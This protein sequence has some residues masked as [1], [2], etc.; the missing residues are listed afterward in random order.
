MPASTCWQCRATVRADRPGERLGHGGRHGGGF[1]PGGVEQR[2]GRLQGH[3][4]LGQPVADGLEG[5]DGSPELHAFQCVGC[6]R[7]RASPAPRRRARGRGRAAPAPPRPASRPARL[8]AARPLEF[9]RHFE[10]AERGVE[11]RAPAGVSAGQVDGEGRERRRPSAATTSAVLGAVECR[12]AQPSTTHQSPSSRP[13]G[14]HRRAAAGR[15][16]TAGVAVTPSAAPAASRAPPTWRSSPPGSRRARRRRWGGRHRA[17]PANRDRR[18]RASSAAPLGGSVACRTPRFEQRTLGRLHQRS[19][20]EVEQPAGDDVALDL[21]AAPV[22][23]GRP[24]IE[25]LGPPALADRVVAERRPPRPALRRRGRTPPARPS[26]PGPCRWRSRPERSPAASRRCVARE[27]A[28]KAHK[29]SVASPTATGSSASG[30]ARGEQLLQAPLQVGGPVPQRRAALVGQ[31]VHGDGPAVIHLAEDPVERH[32]TS[33][34]KT[35]QNSWAP[36]IVSIGR[37]VMPALS[38]SMKS[39]VMPLC[40]DS[41]VPVRVSSTHRARTGPGSS[42]PSGR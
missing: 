7:A 27:R 29:S 34:K 35:S 23:G 18:G 21:G 40:A 1:L 33:S 6:G 9:A 37:T 3:E 28:R 41:G 4:A 5:R 31:E 30:A 24:G 39:A 16:P 25:E 22:D 19:A 14:R 10:Q 13:G 26:P 42:T 2:G 12:G 38:M 11:A 20:P 8:V 17:R 15:L 32:D 36:C